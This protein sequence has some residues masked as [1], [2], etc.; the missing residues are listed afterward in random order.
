MLAQHPSTYIFGASGGLTVSPMT[1]LVFSVDILRT[2]SLRLQRPMLHTTCFRLMLLQRLF[3]LWLSLPSVLPATT[4]VSS[5]PVLSV[6]GT[7]MLPT[8]VLAPRHVTT[9][10]V[11]P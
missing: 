4:Q 10:V 9:C 1:I 3:L 6:F 5:V 11:V 7:S 8:L 2:D